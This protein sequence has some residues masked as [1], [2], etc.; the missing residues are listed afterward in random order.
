MVVVVAAVLEAALRTVAPTAPPAIDPVTR[1]AIMPR[2]LRSIGSSSGRLTRWSVTPQ[3]KTGS[4][5]ASEFRKSMTVDRQ[6]TCRVK[7]TGAGSAAKLLRKQGWLRR[8]GTLSNRLSPAIW[9]GAYCAWGYL[10]IGPV[11]PE[12]RVP[13]GG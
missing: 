1:S 10:P 9:P 2:R 3:P 8:P 7:P 6:L 11:G 4:W 5:K 13:K 12:Q